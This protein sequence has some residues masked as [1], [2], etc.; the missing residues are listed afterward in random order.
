MGTVFPTPRELR[1]LWACWQ[2]GTVTAPEIIGLYD[3]GLH[4]LRTAYFVLAQLERK[5]WAV[6]HEHGFSPAMTRAQAA[7]L[8]TGGTTW[9]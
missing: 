8:L 1:A 9:N 2:Q 6:R 5:G 3:D 4:P 7:Q